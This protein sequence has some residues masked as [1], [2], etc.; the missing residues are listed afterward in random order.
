[1]ATPPPVL[2][3]DSSAARWLAVII[4]SVVFALIHPLWTAPMI[5]I[6]S[7]ALGYVY[8][9]TGSL[10]VPIVMH[11]MFNISSTVLFLNVM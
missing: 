11:A 4:T 7:I 5:F 10:W 8:E 9:R 3:L 6:L 1:M 2:S